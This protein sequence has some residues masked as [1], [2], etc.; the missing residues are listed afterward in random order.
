MGGGALAEEGHDSLSTP[1]VYNMNSMSQILYWCEQTGRSYWEYV[2]QCEG[3]EIWDFLAEVWETMKAA[4]SS[5]LML[6]G[7]C[8]GPLNLR[9][10]ASSYYIRAKGYKDNLQSR[11]LGFCLCAC[12]Q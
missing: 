1:E 10:K 4:D 3:K 6:K 12:G 9:R 7:C 5:G 11:G 8:P 2:E